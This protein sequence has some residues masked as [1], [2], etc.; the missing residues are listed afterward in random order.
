MPRRDSVASAAKLYRP[1][2]QKSIE[3]DTSSKL[4]SLMQEY[5]TA[6]A[7]TI[8][9]NIVNHLE[10]TLAHTRFAASRNAFYQ[11]A[12]LSIRD[13]LIESWNDTQQFITAQ[14]P[15]RVYY[16][17]LEYL[18]GRAM[19]NA[20][21]NM[22]IEQNY[23]EA[24]EELGVQLEELYE[25]ELDPGLGNGGLGRLAACFL[26]SLATLNYPAWGYGIRY[27]YGIF[28]Q[29]IIDSAQVEIPDHWLEKD[30]PWEIVRNDVKYP[31][32]FYGQVTKKWVESVE[33]SKWEGGEIVLAQ[34]HDYPIPGF[35]TFNT[36]NLR[37]WK[38]VPTNEFDFSSFN[39]GDYFRALE[40]RQKAEFISSVLYPNDST[41]SGKELR[42]KQQYFFV[43]ASIHDILRR[44][45]KKKRDWSLLPSKVAI[46]LNDT[47][48]ALAI[49]ELMR[50][51]VDYENFAL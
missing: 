20:L 12:A 46:Q 30:N 27:N 22:D 49:I 51:L 26:D 40:A 29:L 47:H 24:V 37:L 32:R 10:H 35:N 25:E 1:E 43:S 45:G 11:A 31:I 3:G 36:V 44:F 21:I 19:R 5:L 17:S 39:Q 7:Q 8:Q 14:D 34:A 13:R 38:S 23:K 18:L 33:K 15:K 4:W 16:L 6:D 2:Y 9:K 42:L 28:K 41:P 50:I 48:P